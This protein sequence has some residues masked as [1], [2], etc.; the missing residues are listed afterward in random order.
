MK[1]T[2]TFPFDT[3][4]KPH[5]SGVAQ[6]YSAAINAVNC[7][8]ILYFLIKAK[9]SH[10]FMFLLSIFLFEAMHTFSHI[11]HIPG[12]IQLSIVHILAYC[13]NFALLWYAYKTSHRIPN[14]WFD[15]WYAALVGFDIYAFMNLSIIIYLLTQSAMFISTLTYYYHDFPKA[16]REKM[17]WILLF[18]GI[19]IAFIVNESYHCKTMA[20]A[21]P[22]FPFHIFI[23]LNGLV[24]FYLVSSSI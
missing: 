12:K 5:K 19:T 4:E 22:N 2:Y 24:L 7:L 18:I 3:C 16:L 14:G 9:S 20:T 10:A 1:D 6:P 13:A 23:E 15:V 8:V 11:V 21:Y 17:P